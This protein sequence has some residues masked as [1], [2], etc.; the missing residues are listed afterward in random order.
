MAGLLLQGLDDNP[1]SYTFW[2][3]NNQGG[4]TARQ[5]N[6]YHISSYEDNRKQQILAFNTV[7]NILVHLR[8]HFLLQQGKS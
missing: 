4:R 8:H 5:R 1:S 6:N 7:I 3:P 2:N